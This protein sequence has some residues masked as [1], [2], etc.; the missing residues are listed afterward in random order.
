MGAGELVGETGL[1]DAG[2]PHDGDE[3]A[4]AIVREGQR[5]AE[6][7]DLGVSADKPCDPRGGSVEPCPLRARSGERVDLYGARQ[8]LDRDR[9]SG[10]DLHVAFGELQSGG[11]EQDGAGRRHLLHARGQV[12]RQP[13]CRVVHVQI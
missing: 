12:G 13:D 8:T 11:G 9:P 3:L 5:A 6:L 10:D 1:P 2:F 7:L 4:V